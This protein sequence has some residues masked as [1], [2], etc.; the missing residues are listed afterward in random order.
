MNRENLKKLADYLLSGELKAKFNMTFFAALGYT[1]SDTCGTVGCAVGHGPY[2]GIPKLPDEIWPDYAIRVFGIGQED[3]AWCFSGSWDG[4]DNSPIGAAKRIL[5]LL[6][7]G[8]PENSFE[9]LIG[10]EPLSY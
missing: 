2:A 6:E 8:R 5:W 4:V 3:F 9:Q 7:K 1:L 10:T